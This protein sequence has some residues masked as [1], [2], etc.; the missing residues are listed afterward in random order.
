[1]AISTNIKSKIKAGLMKSLIHLNYPLCTI[2]ANRIIQYGNE[3]LSTM[4]LAAKKTVTIGNG[5]DTGRYAKQIHRPRTQHDEITLIAVAKLDDWHGYD[6]IINGISNYAK[7]CKTEI[8]VRFIIVGDGDAYFKLKKLTQ[9]LNLE[10]QIVFTG[11]LYGTDLS[12]AFAEA[13][14]AIGPLGAHRIG[15]S[16]LSSLKVR[17]YLARGLPVVMSGRDVDIPDDI[18]FTYQE[19]DSDTPASIDKIVDWYSTIRKD[20]NLAHDIQEF[21]KRYLDYKNKVH[22]YTDIL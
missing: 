19:V 21:A 14:V 11:P 17:E 22:V 6:R 7:N 8:S 2:F 15:L 1:M 3:E 18:F 10:D 9:S 4:I 20:A 12:N 13:D 16:V 5:I